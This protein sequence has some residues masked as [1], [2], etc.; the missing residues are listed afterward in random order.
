MLLANSEL[1]VLVVGCERTIKGRRSTASWDFTR[2]LVWAG[3]EPMSSTEKKLAGVTVRGRVHLQDT[4]A[5]TIT[6]KVSTEE[7]GL[8]RMRAEGSSVHWADKLVTSE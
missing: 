3:G 8:P 6:P 1:A 7:R 4:I 2:F 5:E